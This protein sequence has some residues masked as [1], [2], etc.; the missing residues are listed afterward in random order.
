VL[1]DEVINV[2]Q[3]G[4]SVLDVGAG[5]GVLSFELLAHG[6]G[7]ATLVDASSA[8]VSAAHAEAERRG[9]DSRVH[10][11]NGDLVRLGAKVDQA[12]V[13]VMHRAICCYP[14]YASLLEAAATHSRRLLVFSY[15]R[16]RWFI[17]CWMAVE[18][19]VLRAAL[20]PDHLQ[21]GLGIPRTLHFDL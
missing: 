16:A 19:A 14:D 2:A 7:R 3:S 12:D 20:P 6:L 15:P 21:Q 9:A 17:R 10:C 18:N 1:L 11:V 13:V 8:Y 4:E 5:V